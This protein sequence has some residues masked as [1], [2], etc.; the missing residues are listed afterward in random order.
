MLKKKKN[1]KRK[2]IIHLSFGKED[3]FFVIKLAC[4]KMQLSSVE[5]WVHVC[6]HITEDQC[7][8]VCSPSDYPPKQGYDMISA[9]ISHLL[10]VGNKKCCSLQDYLKQSAKLSRIVVIPETLL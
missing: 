10:D 8:L 4:C 5:I 7:P 9:L 2:L 6:F 1:N 3:F